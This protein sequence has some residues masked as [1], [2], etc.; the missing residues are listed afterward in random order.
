MHT[1]TGILV[2]LA[3]FVGGGALAAGLT[4]VQVEKTS[5]QTELLK[6]ALEAPDLAV[7]R[8]AVK[9]LTD[10]AALARVADEVKY[11]GYAQDG[12]QPDDRSG[13]AGPGGGRGKGGWS[14]QNC[15]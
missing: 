5:D 2:I 9:K 14:P 15:Q 13:R 11:L 8:A 6:A 1:R 12:R 4:L 3:M 10:R 7:R